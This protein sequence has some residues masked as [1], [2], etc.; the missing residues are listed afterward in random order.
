MRLDDQRRS[1][2]IEDRRGQSGGGGGGM[3]GGLPFRTG[4][5]GLGGLIIV[6]LI[7]LFFPPA[8]Q[9]L[10]ML[11]GGAAPSAPSQSAPAQVGTPT[12][13]TGDQVAA[14]LGSIE[15]VWTKLVA[16]GKLSYYKVPAGQQYPP[17]T[18]VLFSDTVASACGNASS[19][20]GPF[21]CPA[22]SKVYIDTAFF[23][24]LK[25]RFGAPGD[26][27]QAYVIAHEV[28]HHIQNL[29][30][31]A[32]Q[33]AKLRRQLP[34]AEYNVYQVK[35]ELQADC[36]AGVWGFYA[37]SWKNQLEPGDLQEALN[38]ANAI[39]DDRLQKQARGYVVPDSFTHGT[40]EQRMRWFKRGFDSGDPA[41]CDS[42][43]VRDAKQL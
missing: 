37:A 27:A 14:M 13:Q 40:S 12:D 4:G 43:A 7:M 33:V 42:F 6:G 9:F 32:E 34:E 1:Q 38:A 16:E 20:S 8:R 15:D 26:F 10:P 29:V 19:A 41:Q 18:L 23:N 2:N 25:T 5:L 17:A 21:Y 30:G 24:E 3:R 28:G 31:I 35:M 11:L 39:G 22:D 36:F